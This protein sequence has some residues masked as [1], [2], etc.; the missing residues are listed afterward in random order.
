MA[1]TDARISIMDTTIE[2]QREREKKLVLTADRIGSR[3]AYRAK[4]PI[5]ILHDMVDSIC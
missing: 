5:V 4:D 3:V 1:L 2:Q